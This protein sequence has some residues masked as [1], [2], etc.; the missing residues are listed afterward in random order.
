MA[1][2][3]VFGRWQCKARCGEKSKGGG[4]IAEKGSRGEGRDQDRSWDQFTV[5]TKPDNLFSQTGPSGLFSFR[6]EEALEYYCAWDGSS[7]SLVSSRP[8]TQLE[9]EDPVDEGAKDK[10]RSG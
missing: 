8:H 2:E 1:E 6:T 4:N 7:I 3:G 5:A 10:R 9:E